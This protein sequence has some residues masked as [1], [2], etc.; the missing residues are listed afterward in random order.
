[1]R[2]LS[3][4]IHIPFCI[5]KCLYCDF[6]SFSGCEH[7]FG[8]YT[9]SLINEIELSS[10]SY[11]DCEIKTVFFG[12]GTPTF[13]PS[14]LLGKI[15]DTL[16]RCFNIVPDCEIT[17]EANPETMDAEKTASLKYMGANRLSFGVQAF[18][19]R[20][21]ISLGR[22]HNVQKF[23]EAY[24]NAKKAGFE[25]INVDL[26][27]SLPSQSE[28]DWEHSLIEAAKLDITHISCYSLIIEEG[29]LFYDMKKAGALKETN[30]EEDRQMYYAAEDILGHFG[31]LR[32]EISN[33]AKKGFECRH[34][35]VYWQCH[36]Y[37]G[38]GLAAHS[39]FDGIRFSNTEDLLKYISFNGDSSRMGRSREILTLENKIS[40]FMFMGLRLKEGINVNDFKER[41]GMDIKTIYGETFN[42]LLKLGLIIWTKENILLT[43]KGTDISNY[44]FEKLVL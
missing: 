24:D 20:L 35:I 28:K 39:Y 17:F 40:E 33:Y 13:L 42:E 3:I 34:N 27:F 23:F 29:T 21:L 7:L 19:D 5:K 8:Q 18:E 11:S 12:G 37:L 36:E 2:P 22:V 31:F 14:L 44:V 9:D 10:P 4:Y 25:N 16:I 43:K 32:Y 1:M 15:M 6:T 38:F 30:E 26:M 41:F